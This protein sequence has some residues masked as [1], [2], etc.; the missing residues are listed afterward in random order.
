MSISLVK[1]TNTPICLNFRTKAGT[2]ALTLLVR[3]IPDVMRFLVDRLDSAVTVHD[4]DPG[5]PDCEI[6]LDF[7][8]SLIQPHFKVF[9]SIMFYKWIHFIHTYNTGESYQMWISATP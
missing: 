6:R 2:S 1:F 8:Y 4:H 5:D 7:R 9:F 3:K